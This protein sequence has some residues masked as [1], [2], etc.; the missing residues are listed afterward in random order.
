VAGLDELDGGNMRASDRD[1]S[2]IADELRAHYADGRITL[3]EL[4]RRVEQATTAQTI[5]E[6]AVVVHDLPGPSAPHHRPNRRERVGPPGIRPFTRRIVVPLPPERTRA[7]ALDTIATG[8]NGM[9]YELRH[10]SPA[11][12]EFRR[13]RNE[14]IVIDFERQDAK[15]TTM[16]VHG[17]ASR[18]VR[19]HFA[20]LDFG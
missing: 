14:R 7:I 12:M 3:E 10:Q 16:I 13:G 2:K 18:G 5:H 15:T 1:R 8:L 19:K 17:R 6:L 11:R 9:G 20:K 4:D